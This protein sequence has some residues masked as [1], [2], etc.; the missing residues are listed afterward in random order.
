MLDNPL[1]E[2][3]PEPE[4]L[5]GFFW[6]YAGN[7]KGRLTKYATLD[8][9]IYSVNR[10]ASMYEQWYG[11]KVPKETIQEVKDVSD[12]FGRCPFGE[13]LTST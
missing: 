2:G 11:Y 3:P 4:V 7:S 10:I 1:P 9:V 13:V 8:T 12:L 5:C 6:W